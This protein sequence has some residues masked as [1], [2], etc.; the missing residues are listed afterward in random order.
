MIYKQIQF[1]EFSYNARQDYSICLQSI[2]IEMVMY[3]LS[4]LMSLMVHHFLVWCRCGHPLCAN[5]TLIMDPLSYLSQSFGQCSS[6][7]MQEPF[8]KM[9]QFQHIH[10]GMVIA[11]VS[12]PCVSVVVGFATG[13]F[14]MIGFPPSSVFQRIRMHFS[15]LSSYQ[16]TSCV[17]WS[18][19]FCC[20]S[21][22]SSWRCT[23]IAVCVDLLPKF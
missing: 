21:S 1:L 17:W 7:S 2:R 10:I 8:K 3:I 13:G 19:F 4:V 6:P 14:G 9:N 5:T 16:S 11:G 20:F 23:E 18:L 22:A 12:L 15:T